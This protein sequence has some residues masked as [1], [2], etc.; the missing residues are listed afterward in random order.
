MR[1]SKYAGL[2]QFLSEYPED[3]CT[4]SFDEIEN[5]IGGK[6][7]NSVFTHSPEWWS[8][9]NQNYALHWLRAGF[10]VTQYNMSQHFA[11]FTKNKSLA[12][13][14]IS[15]CVKDPCKCKLHLQAV[16]QISNTPT[17]SCSDLLAASENYFDEIRKDEHAR[18]LS[19]EHCYS[20]FQKNRHSPSAEQVDL[21]CLHLAWYLASWGMLRG[22][23]FLLWKDYFVHTPVVK[24][25][26]SEE[27]SDLYELSPLAL[28]NYTVIRKICKLAGEITELYKAE[29]SKDETGER[30]ASDTLVT[31]IILGT[32]GCTP[33]YDRYFKQGLSKSGVAQQRFGEAS[34]T[35][36]A[37]YYYDN[38]D[39]LEKYRTK[40]SLGRVEYPPMKLIDMCFWQLGYDHEIKTKA[41]S[42]I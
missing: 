20:F 11:V 34:L 27:Y 25:L 35:Q 37:E 13:D 39:E 23:A 26:T 6:L 32:M 16:R 22:G 21:L 10:I 14:Y 31:K 1:E 15:R 8:N 42:S 28:T 12:D 9:G 38:L 33:A 30:T 40:T 29:T 36:L 3:K 7:P 5:I 4:L 24:L 41:E 19:W 17:V 18:Y 2:T